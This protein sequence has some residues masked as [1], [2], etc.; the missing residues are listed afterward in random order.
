MRGINHSDDWGWSN[1]PRFG[2]GSSV[3]S[4]TTSSSTSAPWSGQQ[5]YLAQVFGS[6]ADLY[7]DNSAWPQY[8]PASTYSQMTQPQL[9]DVSNIQNYGEGGGNTGLQ[10]AN[11]NLTNALSSGYTDQTGSAFNQ[12]NPEIGSLASGSALNSTNPTF[13]QS[14][15]YLS[16]IL[17]G[18]QLNPFTSPGFSN[19]VNGTLA[20]VIPQTSASFINGGRADSGLAQAAQTAAATNA[21]G[22]LAN[23]NYLGEQ[24]LQ[25]SAAQTASGNQATA[26]NATENAGGLASNNLL[27]QQGN[28][29][30]GDALAPS[31]DQA[32]LGD[33]GAGLTAEGQVQSNSQN[34]LN[35]AVAN[36]NYNQQL[37]FSMLGQFQNYVGGTG[38]GGS[39]TGQSTTPYYENTGSNLLSGGLGG[40]AL[41]SGLGS[42]FGLSSGTG[43]G[44]GA[45]LGA[46]LAFS[47]R[48]LKTDIRKIGESDSGFPLYMFR[49]KTDAPNSVPRIGL[50]AQ[51]VRKKLPEAVAHTPFGM[52]VDYG[53]ALA[54]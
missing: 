13:N 47:D 32:Q 43:A 40:A 19:V 50:M 20:S 18:S 5:P 15:G 41:G 45:G 37:P 51:D 11:S 3:P 38:Y 33:L 23:Q 29:I 2:G 10:S 46:L 6:A 16:S 30:K 9:G 28:Q 42:L 24:Q 53:K 12:A 1:A 52:M 22:S 27:T 54:A 8:Y 48:K 4:T 31:V 14:N 26:L 36:W 34:A 17:S 25:N 7:N 44:L 49:Y 35:A 39:T 21:V